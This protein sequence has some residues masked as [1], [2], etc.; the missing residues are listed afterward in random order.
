MYYNLVLDVWRVARY[1]WSQIAGY[2]VK[3]KV[4]RQTSCVYKEEV[5][6][7]QKELD[8]ETWWHLLVSTP[9]P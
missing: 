1:R 9:S 4:R 2:R 3:A 5:E 6:A 8:V 7:R